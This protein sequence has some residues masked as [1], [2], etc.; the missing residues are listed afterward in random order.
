MN[1][2]RVIAVVLLAA[3]VFSGSTWL[4]GRVQREDPAPFPFDSVRV[5]V[6]PS[7]PPFASYTDAGELVGIDIDLA[8]ALAERLG[9]PVRIEP[10]GIDALF[11][12]LATDRANLVISAVRVEPWRMGDVRYTRTYYNAGLI[13]VSRADD[14]LTGMTALPGRT[15]ALEYGS[16][17][18]AEARRWLRRVQPFETHP[19]EAPGHALDAVRLGVSDAALV[20]ATSAYLYLRDHPDWTPALHHVTD[21]GFVIA[22]QRDQPAA[23]KAVDEALASLLEDGSVE[24]VL[25][26]WLL[27]PQ[28]DAP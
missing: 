6:D 7:Y 21:E 9:L 8:R 20:D 13:L 19:Y 16:D 25:R 23:H 14:Q 22:A 5:A 18:D 12:A 27:P 4:A 10:M 11:D 3:V 17:A 24:A 1:R 28:V 15:L 26:R 2:R